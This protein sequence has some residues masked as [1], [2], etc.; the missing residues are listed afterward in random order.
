MGSWD[1]TLVLL[2]PSAGELF[3]WHCFLPGFETLFVIAGI[4]LNTVVRAVIVAEA[5]S[6][7]PS[8]IS[9]RHHW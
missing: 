2:F 3:T 6:N 8:P 5:L 7:E 1:C 9:V 4:L